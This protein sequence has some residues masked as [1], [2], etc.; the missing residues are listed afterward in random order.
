MTYDIHAHVIG[1]RSGQEG[2]FLCPP[3]QMS[4]PLR[5]MLKGVSRHL[6]S[7]A[8]ASANAALKQL[9]WQ[10]V[11]QSRVDR[12]VLL[13]LDGVFR[14]DGTADVQHTRMVTSNDYVAGFVAGH[15]KLLFGASIHPYRKDALDELDRVVQ[16]GACLIKWLPS[17]Q[18]IAP[19]DPLCAPF[20]ERMAH[21]RIPL[22]THTGVEH[23]LAQFD[24][25][26]NDPQRLV[27]ALRQGVLVIAA[28]CGTRMFLY[29]RSR[30]EQWATLAKEYPGLY[31]DLST[32][33]LPLHGQPLRRILEDAN[34]LSK[35]L[36][37]SDFPTPP[38]PLW[39]LP[40]LGWRKALTL[41]RTRNLLDRALLTMKELGVPEQVFSR[42]GD[43][44]RIP[45]T[46][47][48]PPGGV[49]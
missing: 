24:N 29:E 47:S 21:H 20:Y 39:Y 30:F 38:M 10:W 26:L 41:R 7:G 23:T 5:L 46:S 40:R 35:V 45:V 15:P 19:E 37:G 1:L 2:N 6:P 31:G 9:V 14:R 4:L 42:A 18:N 36:Y 13:A 16:L 3:S 32:F 22:L 33:G 8:G 44:L 48:C 49:R 17:A 28:H 11:S 25:A 34:L 43:L 27:P 12:V